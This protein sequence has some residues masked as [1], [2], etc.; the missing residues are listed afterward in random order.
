[1]A[2]KNT[3]LPVQ[4]AEVTFNVR[5]VQKADAPKAARDYRQNRQAVLD[6]M[7]KLREQRLARERNKAG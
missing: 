3:P 1:M 4:R 7:H 2:F 5:Q 6:Q